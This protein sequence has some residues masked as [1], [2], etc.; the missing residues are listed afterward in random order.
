MWTIKVTSR[1]FFCHQY[2]P[3]SIIIIIKFLIDPKKD[4]KAHSQLCIHVQW[5]NLNRSRSNFKGKDNWMVINFYVCFIE[6]FLIP[7]KNRV[8]LRLIPKR[9]VSKFIAEFRNNSKSDRNRKGNKYCFLQS[10]I[11]IYFA[12]K[13][14]LA[15]KIITIWTLPF[16]LLTWPKNFLL[17]NWNIMVL[18]RKMLSLQI[19]PNHIC[20]YQIHFHVN[21][22]RTT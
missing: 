17:K 12:V 5:L 4:K 11:E 13:W 14:E 15:K 20:S 8:K 1:K 3:Y 2:W 6:H 18:T 21:V 22:T 10:V 7:I 16:S 9:A 19:S